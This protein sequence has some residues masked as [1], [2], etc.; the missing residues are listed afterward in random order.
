MTQVGKIFV[1]AIVLLTSI[2]LTLS[3]VVYGTANDWKKMADKR[4]D[5]IKKYQKDAADAKAQ[6]GAL[7]AQLDELKKEH[8]AAVDELNGRLKATETSNQQFQT[9]VTDLRTKLEKSQTNATNSLVEAEARVAET[10]L[11]RET[12]ANL[13]SLTNRYKEAAL[14]LQDQNVQLERDL[15]VAKNNNKDLRERASL[16]TSMKEELDL[17]KTEMARPNAAS[18][19]LKA[20]TMKL[21]GLISQ[22]LRDPEQVK[23]LEGPPR[24]LQGEITRVD[25]KGQYV[26]LTIG[27]DDGLIP[28][29]KMFVSRMLP[30]PEYVGELTIQSVEPDKALGKMTTTYQG[31]KPQEGDVVKPTSAGR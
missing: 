19:A 16:L 24:V 8:L 10:N 21:V 12:L 9:Q 1:V 15:T 6:A 3:V 4:G 17:L 2:F 22:G 25:V 7:T 13:Q 14:G 27:S 29:H 30:R 18:P 5:E 23:I 31:R 26:E 28:G 11:L 20:R